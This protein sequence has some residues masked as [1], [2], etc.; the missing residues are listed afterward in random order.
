[1][2]KNYT[3]LMLL[4]ALLVSFDVYSL[5][6]LNSLTTATATIYLDFDGEDVNSAVWQ[7]GNPFTCA[8]ANMTDDQVTEVFNR[9]AED[10]RPFNINITTDLNIYLAAPYDT[11]T[12]VIITPTSAWYPGVGGVSYVGSFTWGDDVPCFVFCDR[13]GPNSTKMVAECCSHESGHTVG[14]SHQSSYDGSCNLTSTY[15][16]GTGSGS[17]GVGAY[18]GQ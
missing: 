1:M 13:L 8:P 12:R 7:G 2:K 3:S 17:G 15:N 6:K 18:H 16:A 10:Y 4:L 11:R 9:V 5:P 14:L